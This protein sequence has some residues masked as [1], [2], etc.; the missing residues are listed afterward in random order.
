MNSDN[1]KNVLRSWFTFK[2]RLIGEGMAVGLAAGAVV[3]LY[4]FLLEKALY[5]SKSAY[6]FQLKHP[7]LIPIWVVLLVLGGLL[8]GWIVKKVP[9][10]SGSGIPQ[11]KGVLQHRLEMS[12]WRVILGK[13]LGGVLGI[14]AGLSLG[15]EGPS[16]QLGAAVGQ[17]YSRLFK[18]IKV[19]EGYL[20][21]CGASAGLAAAFNAP[22]SGVIFALE[23]I[24]KNFSPVV[25]ISALASSLAADFVSK[26]FFGMKP[27]FAFGAITP[28]P[29]KNYPAIVVLGIV[30][31]LLGIVFNKAL[32]KSQDLY[33]RLTR[34]PTWV[35]PVIA[36]L[37][38]GIA[39]LALPAVL[40]GGHELVNELMAEHFTLFLL[41]IL[42]LAK[43][44]FTM[45][46][47]GSS[48]PGG[49]FLPLL[50]VGALIG[51]IYWFLLSGWFGFNDA[52]IGN[53]IILAMAGYFTAV[54]KA[55]ITGI[56]LITEM[57]GSFSNLL[58][59]GV[60][61]LT[62]YVIT[63]I[64]KSKP[65][66]EELLERLLKSG[67]SELQGEEDKLLLEIPVHSGSLLEGKRVREMKWPPACLIVGV[68]RGESEL[69]PNGETILCQGDCLIVLTNKEAAAN[70]RECL[71]LAAAD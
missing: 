9:M 17:G 12:W 63:D 2:L 51:R 38:A 3:V 53:F 45:I 49:I 16:I 69:I 6:L 48:A 54:V 35:K 43:F 57:T 21:T 50:V 65:V 33:K 39:G 68:K 60:V 18:K 31:G 11:I 20:M 36:F 14:G 40:G 34:L 47:Y 19:E 27:V 7:W 1:S 62:A 23:E 44:L 55:P 5:F 66:Y 28:L 37:A 29:L 22:I 64:F 26:N 46:S 8:T 15:R 59:L 24:H 32:Y 10:V 52:Y 58:S 70:V 25:M 56:I 13:L 42:L 71:A 61:C 4:R 41:I 67:G 30:A